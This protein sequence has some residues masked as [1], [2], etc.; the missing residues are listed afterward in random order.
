VAPLYSRQLSEAKCCRNFDGLAIR[1]PVA[2]DPRK[3]LFPLD[4][5]ARSTEHDT[6]WACWMAPAASADSL[7]TTFGR[8]MTRREMER[9]PAKPVS[10][11]NLDIRTCIEIRELLG[12]TQFDCLANSIPSVGVGWY[13][14]RRM[15]GLR[16]TLRAEEGVAAL[17]S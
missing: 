14:D 10:I 7:A 13:G 5:V 15:N 12:I 1:F 8:Q 9:V 11:S 3:H 16:L 2:L 17:Q 4:G 6:V